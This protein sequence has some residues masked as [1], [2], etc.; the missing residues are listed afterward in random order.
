[1]RQYAI[2]PEDKAAITS[3]S[4]SWE[5]SAI[6]FISLFISLTFTV[7][8]IPF[9]P[10]SPKSIKTIS[11]VYCSISLNPSVAL[12]DS[13]TTF[14]SSL[15]LRAHLSPTLVSLKSSIIITLIVFFSALTAAVL[16]FINPP[17]GV[18]CIIVSPTP[19]LNN[20]PAL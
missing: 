12:S 2:A 9:I 15:E 14:I 19:I 11:G 3:S 17:I 6:T 20:T 5:V 10:A 4:L 8:S 18:V 13:A 1:M 7:A 16:I